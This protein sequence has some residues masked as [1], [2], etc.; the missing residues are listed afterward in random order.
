[1]GANGP[2]NEK[3][4]QDVERKLDQILKMLERSPQGL[5]PSAGRP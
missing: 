5:N 1:L 3:R 2:S 4:L